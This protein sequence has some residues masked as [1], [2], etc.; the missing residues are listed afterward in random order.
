MDRDAPVAV[1]GATSQVGAA[2]VRALVR[3]GHNAVRSLPGDGPDPMDAAA[4]DAFFARAHPA[5][6]VVV[7]IRSGGILANEQWPAD[8]MTAN[9][10]ADTHVIEAAH[11]HRVRK[12]LY[13][14]SSCAYPR[15][16]RQPMRVEDLMTGPLEPTSEAYGLA[17]LAGMALCRAFRR[18]YGDDFIAAIP[19]DAFG[20][21]DDFSHDGAHVVAALI[22]RLHE[23]RERGAP[24]ATVWGTGRAR[25]QFM[26]VD[27]V[28]DACLFVMRRY[29]AEVPINLGGGAIVSIRE[30]AE[31]I[32]EVVGYPGELEFDA[33]MPDGM[34]EKTLD[35]APLRALG[36]APAT[37][38]RP[39]LDATYS[40]FR[41]RASA[42]AGIGGC[43]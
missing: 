14:A 28:A 36:W 24:R 17:K 6:V 12:L 10:R 35:G 27:D 13:L 23:A 33:S 32:R 8:L 18:Q 25:H 3:D 4:L 15:Q 39:G 31:L 43:W 26:F 1:V 11:R 7:S 30:V 34:P 40:W 37:G 19:P 29:S 38:L 9:L 21:E 42:P 16:C 5:Y 20:P 22:S 41:T 2:I